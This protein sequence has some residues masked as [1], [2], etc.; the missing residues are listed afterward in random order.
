MQTVWYDNEIAN[1]EIVKMLIKFVL[2]FYFLVET[3]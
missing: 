1:I 3:I 2:Y